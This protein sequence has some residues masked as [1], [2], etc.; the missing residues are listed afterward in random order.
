MTTRRLPASQP[1]LKRFSAGITP[2]RLY[3]TLHADMHRSIQAPTPPLQ[4]HFAKYTE[5]V[6]RPANYADSRCVANA[7]SHVQRNILRTM[8]PFVLADL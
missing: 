6:D 5:L 3:L 2:R 7:I 4:Q 8:T 1:V